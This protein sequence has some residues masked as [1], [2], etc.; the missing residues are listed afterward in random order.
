MLQLMNQTEIEIFVLHIDVFPFQIIVRY[1]Y[2]ICPYK[3]AFLTSESGVLSNPVNILLSIWW[4]ILSRSTQYCFSR[5]SPHFL[6]WC[7]R[8]ILSDPPRHIELHVVSRIYHSFLRCHVL[9][10]WNVGFFFLIFMLF[11]F[12]W[13]TLFDLPH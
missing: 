5:H 12:T 6:T 10:T 13:N 11:C 9:W 2:I 1:A 3:H 7:M 4:V 8:F